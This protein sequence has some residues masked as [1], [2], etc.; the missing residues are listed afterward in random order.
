MFMTLKFT[1]EELLFLASIVFG[2]VAV[3]HV[4]R[5]SFGWVI[6]FNGAIIPMYYSYII[7]GVTSLLAWRLHKEAVL[8]VSKPNGN[9]KKRK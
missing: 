9:G 1:K 8:P 4:L 6:V 2:V 7:V 5:I 3:L